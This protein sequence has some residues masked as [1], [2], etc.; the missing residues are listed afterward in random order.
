MSNFWQEMLELCRKRTNYDTPHYGAVYDAFS[1]GTIPFLFRSE[2]ILILIGD[3]VQWML[4]C[5]IRYSFLVSSDEIMFLKLDIKEKKIGDKVVLTEPWLNYSVPTKIA[6]SFDTEKRTVT[7]RMGLLHL[8]WMTVQNEQDVWCL[9][10]ELGY[11][12]NYATF[13][14]QNEHWKPRRP[15]V[16]KPRRQT[17]NSRGKAS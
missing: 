4:M 13:T 1:V 17:R 15:C 14:P 2:S 11:S 16:P 10:D 3:I 5:N 7:I 8:L 9:P 6:D 12:L